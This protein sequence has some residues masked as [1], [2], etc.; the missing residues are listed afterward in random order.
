MLVQMGD[1]CPEDCPGWLKE[2]EIELP[3]GQRVRGTTP[4][5]LNAT[6]ARLTCTEGHA[7]RVKEWYTTAHSG[8]TVYKLT[9]RITE[10]RDA[11]PWCYLDIQAAAPVTGAW[12]SWLR[13]AMGSV[14]MG[15]AGWSFGRDGYARMEV[16]L[17]APSHEAAAQQILELWRHEAPP[18]PLRAV[19]RRQP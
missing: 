10:G 2:F 13:A 19:T 1:Q 17:K 15:I 18:V 11:W 12:W 5:P 6:G 16:T 9:G 3:E 8:G 7:W 4:A 14:G